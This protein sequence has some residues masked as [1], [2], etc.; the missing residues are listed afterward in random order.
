V[1]PALFALL[2]QHRTR[3]RNGGGQARKGRHHAG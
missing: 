3:S 1:V 2:E